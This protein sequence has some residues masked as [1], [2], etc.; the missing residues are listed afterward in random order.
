MTALNAAFGTINKSMHGRQT[1]V[2]KSS[3]PGWERVPYL[4]AGDIT[5]RASRTKAPVQVQPIGVRTPLCAFSADR[6]KLPVTGYL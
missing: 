6:V 2:S 5:A 1:A 3:D 4:K